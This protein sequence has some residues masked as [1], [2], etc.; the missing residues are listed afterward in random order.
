MKSPCDLIYI[1]N[2]LYQLSLFKIVYG[3]HLQ[4]SF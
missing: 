1:L 3:M 4:I 2:G